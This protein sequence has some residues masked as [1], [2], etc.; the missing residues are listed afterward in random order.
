[1]NDYLFARR[2]DVAKKVSVHRTFCWKVE[3][4]FPFEF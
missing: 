4:P 2:H 1:M 3:I